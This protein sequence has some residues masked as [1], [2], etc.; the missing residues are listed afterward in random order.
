MALSCIF[1]LSSVFY[2]SFYPRSSDIS[3]FRPAKNSRIYVMTYGNSVITRSGV[4]SVIPA[5][6]D[7]RETAFL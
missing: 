1:N 7:A 2:G 4:C 3:L 5:K 6:F